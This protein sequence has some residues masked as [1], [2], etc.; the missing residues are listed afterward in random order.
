MFVIIIF[1]GHNVQNP[2][3]KPPTSIIIFVWDLKTQNAE[4]IC[5]V[6]MIHASISSIM[7]FEWSK[8]DRW[9]CPN[10]HG[11][12]VCTRTSFLYKCQQDLCCKSFVCE[13]LPLLDVLCYA[14]SSIRFKRYVKPF[15]PWGTHEHL[16]VE[17][18]C[19]VTRSQPPW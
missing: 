17:G 8:L 16:I 11:W 4:G 2:R 1:G 9:F 3:W 13:Y 5:V 18:T 19:M 6:I 10:S 14:Q 7:L 15:K 12:L